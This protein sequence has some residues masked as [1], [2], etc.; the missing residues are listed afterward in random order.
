MK[1]K[2]VKDTIECRKKIVQY[3]E[4]LELEEERIPEDFFLHCVHKLLTK[5]SLI[6]L[7]EVLN[8]INSRLNLLVHKKDVNYDDSNLFLHKAKDKAF[9][10][11]ILLEIKHGHIRRNSH[12]IE[13]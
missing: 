10:H 8:T 4:Y 11:C 13:K 6:A 2:D 7:R 12:S 9:K 3:L 5:A 1:I